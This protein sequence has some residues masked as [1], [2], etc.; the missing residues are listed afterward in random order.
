MRLRTAVLAL[1]LAALGAAPAAA[2][3]IPALQDDQIPNFTGPELERRLD[4][5]ASTGTKVTRIDVL[6]S[7]VATRRPATPSDPGD[8]AYDWSRYDQVFRG[9]ARRGISTIVGFYHTPKWASR[10]GEPRAAP[11]APDA[12]A[13]IGALAR[14]YNGSYPDPQGGTLP[15]LKRIEVWNEPNIAQFYFPQCRRQG[16]R[17]VLDSPRTYAALLKMS[18]A[19]I[20][21]ASPRAIVVGGVA[22][23]VGDTSGCDSAESSVGTLTFLEELVRQRVPLDAW[24][25]HLYPLGAPLKAYFVPSWSTMPRLQRLVDKLR[26]GAPIYVTETGYHTSYNR[27]HRYF[28]TE[29][30]QAQWV[31]ETFQAAAKYPRVEV[32]TW[33]NLQDNPFWTGG[34]LRVDLSR[35]PAWARFARA[36][37]AG[38]PPA[39]WAS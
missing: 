4:L 26:R 5:L 36:A 20:K 32:A 6:W 37:R 35:K 8:P 1:S 7:L 10:S 31:D 15:F 33:F 9:L 23:P 34:L 14:R 3:P 39:G 19:A 12:S 27:F 29:R 17:F 13:F 38:A 2:A 18:Y 28:V 16:R 22:G 25:Q 24:S 11:R 21:T 30:Q